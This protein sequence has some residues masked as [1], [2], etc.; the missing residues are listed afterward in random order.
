M[1]G[2]RVK[3]I[4][5]ALVTS[6]QL[7]IGGA[8]AGASPARATPAFAS[9]DAAVAAGRVDSAVAHDLAVHGRVEA[10]VTYAS[11]NAVASARRAAGS[12]TGSSRSKTMIRAM[13]DAFAQEKATVATTTSD[14]PVLS[15]PEYLPVRDV[16]IHNASQ[17]LRLAAAS[18]VTGVR[19]APD[20]HPD[21]DPESFPLVREPQAVSAGYTG[22][23]TYVAVLDSGVNVTQPDFGTCNPSVVVQPDTCRVA[24]SSNVTTNGPAY[25]SS[26]HGTNVSAV[27]A[28][29]APATR[30]MTFGVFGTTN[31]FAN[32]QTAINDTI[33]YK[34]NGINV[35]A[36]NLS[37]G[38][39]GVYSATNPCPTDTIGLGAAVAAGILPVVSTGNNT[40]KDGV[41]YPACSANALAVGAVYDSNVGSRTWTDGPP[42]TDTTT[43]ADK[44]TCFSQSGTLLDVFAPG[45]MITAG[46]GTWWGTSQ[47]APHVAG[48]AAI[49]AAASPSS[50]VAALRSALVST[51]PTLT[52]A[53]AGI[54][55]HRL[56][57]VSALNWI[58]DKTPPAVRAP[59]AGI[60]VGQRLGY[61]TVPNAVPV[62]VSWS[63]TDANGIQAYSPYFTTNGGTTWT[64]VNT[65]S[66]TSTSSTL[67][68]TPGTTVQFAVRAEDRV[69]NWSAWT[70]GPRFTV[71]DDA[72]NSSLISYSSGWSRINVANTD[73]GTLTTSGVTGAYTTFNFTG[74]TFAWVAAK[75]TNRGQADV[76]LD[77]VYKGRLDLGASTLV[78]KA[79][80]QTF[81]FASSAA[82]T[83]QVQVVG[84]TGRPYVDVDSM[85]VLR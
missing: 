73:G 67:W 2:T 17:L 35:V 9:V 39:G 22:A 61:G 77:G 65:A 75:A 76:W 45:A 20:L 36:M 41:A 11:D 26:G 27:V 70:Y 84:T 44:V 60:A 81:T 23:G 68:V 47:A 18:D 57:V 49:L 4:A 48:T 72:D 5:T 12:A 62:S 50:S 13:R 80:V 43:W 28:G 58:L 52:D 15:D 66:A 74:R 63:A 24:L 82:H 38:D 37:L 33:F 1:V 51:G 59:A 10:V 78:T 55:R 16:E 54:T 85:I 34:Q 69:G 31:V 29:L 79:V 53:A 7:V 19:A 64:K 32:V 42:C 30:V 71:D 83:V 14:V 46:G 21:G 8:H 40:H 3:V 25:D 56:D 6:V